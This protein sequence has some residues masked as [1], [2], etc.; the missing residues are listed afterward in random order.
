MRVRL[1]FLIGGIAALAI[2]TI[3]SVPA[4]A[5]PPPAGTPISRSMPPE[6]R[7]TQP[8]AQRVMRGSLIVVDADSLLARYKAGHDIHLTT[9]NA[10][11]D[12]VPDSA[13]G[14][15]IESDT[16]GD[17][18]VDQMYWEFSDGTWERA[19]DYDFDTDVDALAIDVSA[20]DFAD[21][22]FWDNGDNSYWCYQD[23]D[24]DAVFETLQFLTRSQLDDTMPGI[25][26][27]LDITF[28]PIND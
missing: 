8:R 7:Q 2:S 13:P 21:I 9:E 11:Y 3:A 28:G 27:F 1:S 17:G 15:G 26:D 18:M 23:S 22:Q 19:V 16:N 14:G 4:H 5:A 6:Q 12:I 25:A 20:D 24:G 10:H